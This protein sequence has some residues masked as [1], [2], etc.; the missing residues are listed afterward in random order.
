MHFKQN[1]FLKIFKKG[2]T[3]LLIGLIILNCSSTKSTKAV[4]QVQT[5]WVGTWATAP[6]LVEPHNMPPEPGLTN[7]TIRQIV[8]VSIGG[9][10][11]RLRFNNEFSKSPVTMKAVQI[12]VSVDSSVINT[13]TIKE[14]KFNGSTEVTMQPG[15]AITSDA[16]AFPLKPRMD[17]A[18]TI[19]F[20]ETS[21]TATGH[22]G[23]RTTSYIYEGN[24]I[25]EENFNQA[26]KTDH[27]YVING[28]DVKAPET[29]NAVVVLGNSI[30][31][32]RG[33]GTNK[34]NRWPDILS[35][36]LLNNPATSN[37]GVLNMGIGGNAVLRGGLGPTALNRFGRDVLSQH[38]V[39]W[40]IILEGVND[41]GGTRNAEA[42]ENVADGLIEAYAKMIEDAHAQNIKVYG[43][44]ILPIDKSFYYKDYRETARQ[45]INKWIRTSGKFDAV[46]DFDKAMS[47]PENPTVILP[48]AHDGDFLHPNELGYE[49]MGGAVDLKLFE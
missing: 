28:I 34:Q 22:P 18:I 38:G 20:G 49:I 6:Q 26:V 33:S 36:R 1:Y 13:G 35:Q 4:N 8:R 27:W 25:S 31:D 47:D 42:A 16:L 39:K 7:N 14:L 46:I 15:T 45:R 40:L 44:T 43:A 32:G 37:I 41:L 12:A 2:V 21:P 24:K 3:L 5:K 19:Y 23:S 9:D 11:I 17:L 30:T 29:A 10:S 48:N